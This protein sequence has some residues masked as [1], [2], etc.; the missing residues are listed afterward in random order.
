MGIVN[1]ILNLAGLLL[2]LNWRSNRFDPLVRRMPATLMGTLRPAAP[3]KL[4]RWH[5]LAFIAVLLL[6]RAVIYWQIGKETNWAGKLDLGV[7][8]LWFASN[9]HWAG[10]LRM[11]VF[12]FSSFGL[13][14]GVF[15]LW[16]LMLSLLAGPLPIHGLVTIPLGRVDRWPRWAKIVLPF[17]VTGALWWLANWVF[18]QLQIVTPMPPA[19]R[20]Q[21]A[22]ILGVV[23]YFQWQYPLEAILL[24]HLLNSYVYFGKHPFWKYIAAT[25][26][27]ILGPL[28]R[29]PLQAGKVDF[30]P[31]VGLVLIFL[32]AN[33]VEFGIKTPPR[34][35]N[36]Q[37]ASPLVH[38]PGLID[39]YGKLPL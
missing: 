1:F 31:L 23:G 4:R 22:L 38:V 2:W 9:S 8:D 21:Q 12:S 3:K 24:L 5:L 17:I 18:A 26:Q 35:K 29:I 7:V 32:V 36:G 10:F 37:A 34:M 20:F 6:F 27:T 13:M 16:V 11:V 30:A 28:R 14:L 19:G 39:L 15:Y 33:C 25:A